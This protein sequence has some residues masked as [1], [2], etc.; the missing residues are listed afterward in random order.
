MCYMYL[1]RWNKKGMYSVGGKKFKQRAKTSVRNIE[2][3]NGKT[4]MTFQYCLCLGRRRSNWR[5]LGERGDGTHHKRNFFHL[6][7]VFRNVATET[8]ST[9]S[10]HRC[11]SKSQ[12]F[13]KA[14]T[15]VRQLQ[16]ISTA[17]CSLLSDPTAFQ[18]PA[19]FPYTTTAMGPVMVMSICVLWI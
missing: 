1:K 16:S 9:S 3:S 14:S 15:V 5:I 11:C 4:C 6:C 19:R 7:K 12:S 8:D 2:R 13:L 18:S 17:Y 10:N